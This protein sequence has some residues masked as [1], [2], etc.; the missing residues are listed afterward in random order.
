LRF[1]PVSERHLFQ[2]D[3]ESHASV[4]CS[5]WARVLRCRG[6]FQHDV[7]T[8]LTRDACRLRP[9]RGNRDA[10]STNRGKYIFQPDQHHQGT[11]IRTAA[12]GKA[13]IRDTALRYSSYRHTTLGY[14]AHGN[15]SNGDT[16][17]GNAAYKTV[18]YA[19]HECRNCWASSCSKYNERRPALLILQP[20]IGY[21][22]AHLA[23]VEV[24][25]DA[26][27]G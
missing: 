24:T 2:A 26:I 9:E 23:T 5:F 4:V 10:C 11:P 22:R 3:F 19:G 8:A 17:D 25:N 16:T 27:G 21:R 20:G 15:T 1:H 6:E 12:T 18:V 7:Q 13:T 14:S